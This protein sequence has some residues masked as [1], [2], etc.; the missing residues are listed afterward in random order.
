MPLISRMWGCG[1]RSE[2]HSSLLKAGEEEADT[3]LKKKL[4]EF[5]DQ[6]SLVIGVICLLVWVMNL[7]FFCTFEWTEGASTP[8]LHRKGMHD[9]SVRERQ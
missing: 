7:K 5:G 9:S 2:I 8:S 1:G 4:D 6:L 3:P